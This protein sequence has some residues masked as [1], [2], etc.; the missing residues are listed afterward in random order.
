M[1]TAVLNTKIIEVENKI[2]DTTSRLV[3]TTVLNSKIGEVENKI[4]D[5]AKYITTQIFNKLMAENIAARLK[6]IYLARKTDFHSK[7]TSFNRNITSNKTKYLEVQ[8]NLK[9]RTTKDKFFLG[10]IYFTSTDGS[11]NKFV[12]QPTLDTSELKVL[13]M[14]LVENQSEYFT[15]NLS[16]D[17]DPLAVEQKNYFNRI[18]N[19]YISYD[20]NA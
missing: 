8:K 2:P 9:I 4:P 6:Q 11:Q 18:I 3:T 12:Y 16:H 10:R 13:I 19:F 15:L 7:I 14:F 17:K 1:T 5:H 20:L